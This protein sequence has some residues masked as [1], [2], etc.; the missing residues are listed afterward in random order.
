MRIR[1]QLLFM[2]AAI[3]LPVMLAVGVAFEK[4]QNSERQAALRGLSETVRAT[5]LIVDREVQGSLSA[6]KALGNSPHLVTGDFQSFHAQAQ[7]LDHPPDVWTVLLDSSG[8]QLV[9]TVLPYGAPLPLPP[10]AVHERVTRT[11]ATQKPVVSDLVLGP[12]TG[13]LLT[14]IYVPTPVGGGKSMVVGQAFSVDF[15]K[16]TAMQAKLPSDWVVGVVDKNGRF[17]SRSHNAEE[18]LGKSARPEL[19]SAAAAANDGLIRHLTLDG[20]E[21]YDAFTHSEL[22]GWTIAVAAPVET[23]EA[24]A[25]RAI[26]MALAGMLL[27]L[28][29]AIVAVAVFG[30]NFILAI[31]RARRSARVLGYG[32]K[33]TMLTTS[34]EEVNELN[35]AIVHAGFLLHSER[36]SRRQAEAERERLLDRVMVARETAE[37]QNNAK[38]QFLAMLGHELRSPLAA[39][40]AA[41]ALL[42]RPGTDSEQFKRCVDI[43]S[44]QNFHLGRIV[45]DLLDI[46]RLVAGK[47][48]LKTVELNLEDV[49]SKYVAALRMTGRDSG[50]HI[51]VDAGPAW[52][53]GD[54]VRI[55]QILS[56]LVNNALKFSPAGGE[57]TISVGELKGNAFLSVHDTGVGMSAE[58]LERVFDP[59]VQG[60]PSGDPEHGGLGIGLALVRQLV[61][62]HHGGVTAASAG[63]GHGSLFTV[64]IPGIPAPLLPEVKKPLEAQR[65]CK[66]VYVE[67]NPDARATM[68]D[69]LASFGYEVVQAVDG[70]GALAAVKAAR[71][72]VVLLDIGLPDISGYEVARRLGKDPAVSSI[73]LVAL[74]GYGFQSDKEAAVKAGFKAYVL[75]PADP[76]EIL[77]VILQVL[78]AEA[79]EGF[80][81]V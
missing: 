28:V 51:V 73:P 75:K 25:R 54:P 29:A 39:I 8:Q 47:I 31:D 23:I 59:F 50:Q 36:I 77:S 5:A 18:L 35:R 69:L 44:R 21:A 26:N 61:E 49:V 62:L 30:R 6:M 58:L 11:I 68:S 14:T 64:R 48:E 1:T 78:E 38:D 74:T 16:K 40:S 72:D 22:T 55:E 76:S 42:N 32:D 71:P 4:I 10:P 33:P 53:L 57:I 37:A 17:I 24:T 7:A 2:S 41:S 45:D 3:L 34:I 70:Y 66:I 63:P 27:A 56:N 67:D 20:V 60:P 12:A 15:W 9:N 81:G 79:D 43:I 52:I 19:V 80:V 65:K 13:K 46:N